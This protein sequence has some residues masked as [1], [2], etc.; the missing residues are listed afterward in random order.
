ML[1]G[2]KMTGLVEMDGRIRKKGWIPS[3]KKSVIFFSCFGIE[4]VVSCVS[5]DCSCSVSYTHLTLPTRRTV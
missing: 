5:D 1:K 4:T 3:P 2:G